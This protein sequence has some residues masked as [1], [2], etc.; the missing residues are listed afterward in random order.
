MQR[1]VKHFLVLIFLFFS[2]TVQAATEIYQ[3][4]P[5]HTYVAWRVDHFG[6]SHISGKWMAQGKITLDPTKPQDSKVEVVIPIADL[7]TGIK[8]AC[9]IYQDP[10]EIRA[11]LQHMQP[12][13]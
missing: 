11:L 7:T 12:N 4:D 5:H 3:L 10:D 13:E 6:F 1:S 9:V 8:Q 2:T